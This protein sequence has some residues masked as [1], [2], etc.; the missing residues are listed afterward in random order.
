[1]FLPLS[2]APFDTPLAYEHAADKGLAQ[3][4]ERLGIAKG[5]IVFRLNEVSYASPVRIKTP[6][7]EAIL[8][9]GMASKVII[10]HDD[11]HK[12]PISEMQPNEEGHVEGL[13]CG[14]SLEQGLKTLG[15]REN[16][17][18]TMIRRLPPMDY[19]TLHNGMRISLTEGVASKLWGT[20]QGREMQFASAGKGAPFTITS[21]LG[22]AY[23]VSMLRR[24]GLTPGVVLELENVRPASDSGRACKGHNVLQTKPGL[25]LHLRPDQEAGILVTP[26]KN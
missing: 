15:I 6:T 5:D 4:L 11:G 9:V 16:D 1:M 25:R 18:I 2:Q 22:G 3:R 12:T 17:R 23:S 10:H 14:S 19:I 26:V 24:L 20:S 8:G 7:G 13:V 21:L